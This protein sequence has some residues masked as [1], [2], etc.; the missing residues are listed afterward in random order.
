MALVLA[1]RIV[2]AHPNGFVGA[3]VEGKRSIGK[4][5]Y[6]IKVCKEVFKELEDCSENTAY[7]LALDHIVFSLDDLIR[8]LSTARKKHEMIPVLVWD[9]AGV[10]GSSLQYFINLKGVQH[11]KAITDTVRTATTGLLLTCPDREGLLKI[12]RGYNDYL[13]TIT[14]L[15]GYYLRSAR[16]YNVYKLPS[17]M[18]RVYRNFDDRYSCYLPKWVYNKYMIMTAASYSLIFHFKS[19]PYLLFHKFNSFYCLI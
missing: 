14:K 6:T 16:G 11:M 5:S 1:K 19:S 7:Q 10:H 17:G 4:S 3:V 12:L 13:V 8:I 18:K 15:N 2:K 9:D